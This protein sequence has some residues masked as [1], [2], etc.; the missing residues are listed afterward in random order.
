M[1]LNESEQKKLS[2]MVGEA[3]NSK[4]RIAAENDLL[5]DIRKRAK[6]ELEIKPKVFNQIVKIVMDRSAQQYEEETETVLELAEKA[7]NNDSK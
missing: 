5:K 4:T 3:V 6:D 1:Q 2:E 7:V